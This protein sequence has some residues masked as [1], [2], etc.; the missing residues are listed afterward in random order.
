MLPPDLAII[1]I[2]YSKLALL[3]GYR[4]AGVAG[5]IIGVL[6]YTNFFFN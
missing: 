1:V 3:A 5:I 4:G 6:G 2:V